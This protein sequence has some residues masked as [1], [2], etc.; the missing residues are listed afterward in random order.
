MTQPSANALPRLLELVRR[1]VPT[2]ANRG[3]LL[4]ATE[5][6]QL[7]RDLDGCTAVRV[8]PPSR[9]ASDSADF[10]AAPLPQDK[11]SCVVAGPALAGDGPAPSNPSPV[12]V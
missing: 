4:L 5:M 1:A 6:K 9:R 10:A 11:G 8:A 3:L 2:V 12:E 7:A